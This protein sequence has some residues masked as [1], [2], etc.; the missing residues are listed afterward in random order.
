MSRPR[1]RLLP[2]PRRAFVVAVAVATLVSLLTGIAHSDDGT[3]AALGPFNLKDSRGI[4]ISQYQLSLDSGN[5]TDF[6]RVLQSQAL[7]GVW[8]VYRMLIGF[9]AYVVDWAVAMEWVTWITGPVNAAATSIHDSILAPLH[10]DRLGTAGL[11]GLL[12][13]A[14]GLV[15]A[16][17]AARGYTGRALAEVF[18]SAG[19]AAAVVGV[20]A[21]PVVTFAG[22]GEEPA[23]PLRVAQRVGLEVSNLILDKPLSSA[24]MESTVD[25]GQPPVAESVQPVKTGSLLV[26]TFVRPVHQLVNYGT[27]IDSTH[28]QCRDAYDKA[29]KGGPYADTAQARSSVGQ[30]DRKLQEFAESSSWLRVIGLNLYL[31][32]AGLLALLVLL[33]VALLVFAVITLAWSALKL[34]VHAPLAIVPGDTRGPSIRDLVDVAISLVYVVSGLAAL[35]IVIKLVNATLTD[36]RGVPL[37]V[38]FVGIDLM[39]IAG[40]ALLIFNYIAHRR[41]ARSMGERIMARL[42]QS[43]RKGPDVG[44]RVTRWLAQPSFASTSPAGAAAMRTGSQ[45]AHRLN[46]VTASNGFQLAVTAGK[47]AA[48]GAT[49]GVGVLALTGKAAVTAGT[50]G[51]RAGRAGAAAAVQAAHETSNAWRVHQGLRSGAR[52]ATTGRPAVDNVLG[53]TARAHQYLD[54]HAQRATTSTATVAVLRLTGRAPASPDPSLTV[55]TSHHEAAA[56]VRPTPVRPDRPPTSARQA[57]VTQASARQTPVKLSDP[58]Q[59]SSRGS[60]PDPG[61]GDQAPVQPRKPAARTSGHRQRGPRPR[62]APPAAS[63]SARERRTQ[64]ARDFVISVTPTPADRP[65]QPVKKSAAPPRTDADDRVDWTHQPPRRRSSA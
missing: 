22:N 6:A 43:P 9:I 42:R 14:A 18:V 3:G 45:H 59:P 53:H 58:G 31:T 39:L 8:D 36:T 28:Q 33:F 46:R 23:A 5:I 52:H 35:S 21:A 41:G 30:C 16:V 32:T 56:A 15:I 34:I 37:Q 54:E 17:H 20:L 48:G 2:T 49:M 64:M 44:Q 61:G 29:L 4:L 38:R 55:P 1:N 26:D 51:L 19:V 10:L 65:G 25:A 7:I 57:S 60:R 13:A 11:M 47:V 63:P 50:V 40:L 12:L 62:P 27:A 24:S